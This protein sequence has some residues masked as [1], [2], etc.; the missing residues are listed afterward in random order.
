[1]AL[2]SA[3]KKVLQ[4]FSSIVEWCQ[5]SMLCVKKFIKSFIGCL[6]E[7]FDLSTSLPTHLLSNEIIQIVA[8]LLYT[9]CLYTAYGAMDTL[10]TI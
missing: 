10:P 1:M 8:S 7:F 4:L 6:G 3:A 5:G 9:V 2:T